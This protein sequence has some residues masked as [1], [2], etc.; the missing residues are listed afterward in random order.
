MVTG[1][2][3]IIAG[4]GSYPL[5]M[6]A[7]ARRAGCTVVVA[8]LREE[9]DPAV[10]KLADRVLWVGLTQLGKLIRF[11][12]DEGVERAVMA[13]QVIKRR[14]YA[15]DLLSLDLTAARL[16]AALPDRKG[17]TILRAVADELAGNG[18]TLLDATSFMGEYLAAP[19]V[20]TRRHPT[21]DET[22]DVDFGLLMAKVV[23]EHD[24]GQ[25][26]A[27]KGL[28]VV[29]VEAAEG[30]DACILRAGELCGGG[31]TLVKVARKGHDMRFDVPVTGMR[32]IE[33]LV[34]AKAS[35]LAVEAGR[36]LMLERDLLL[37]AADAA[38]IAV[39]GV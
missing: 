13:G 7:N 8:A 24:I 37:D 30:T 28:S 4:N 33:T 9:A 3:G 21:P 39:V 10:E 1:K 31:F 29:A 36:T 25:S 38:G 2:I 6:A 19:G 5:I 26:V 11:F 15:T 27:V 23:A 32:T 12:R 18:I 14:M 16:W 22:G 34:R 35:V 17:E 20:M